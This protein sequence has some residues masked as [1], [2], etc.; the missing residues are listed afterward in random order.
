MA[1]YLAPF[2]DL[3]S[4]DD[5]LKFHITYPPDPH[6][7]DPSQSMRSVFAHLPE[8]NRY[9][10][11]LRVWD[12]VVCADH[13]FGNGRQRSPSI[14]IGHGA[15]SK[16][17]TS[18]DVEY[19]YGPDAMDRHHRPAYR[20]MLEDDEDY[21]TAAIAANPDLRDVI[22]VVGHPDIDRLPA[23]VAQRD[24]FRS[25]LGFAPNDRVVFF[26]STWGPH[27]LFHVM[28]DAL[29]EQAG[30]MQST[31]RFILSIH[32]H[33]YRPAPAGKR[34]W[35]PYLESL[36]PDGFI[37]RPPREDW[38]PYLIASDCVVSDYCGLIE[39]AVRLQKPLVFTPTPAELI[40]K[41]SLMWKARQ[42]FPVITDATQLPT[43]IETAMA[44]PHPIDTLPTASTA[45]KHP[46]T[47]E[48]NIRRE[49]CALLNLSVSETDKV[50]ISR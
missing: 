1:D 49:I 29:L 34:T 26:L 44:M 41:S 33:E 4:T 17:A 9:V 13:C 3:F 11:R 40:W 12:L 39:Y 35:G 50:E 19:T 8:I 14:Y 37:V 43:A 15:K 7:E 21:A 28:G 18:D 22:K 24:A 48:T 30:Q 46:G 31:H 10:A 38:L 45:E 20:V 42:S 16:A 27:S 32:S 6:S 36:A 2:L 47:T 5:R 25:Q 23:A